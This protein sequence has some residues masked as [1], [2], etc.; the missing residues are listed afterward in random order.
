MCLALG[1]TR[2]CSIPLSPHNPSPVPG[3]ANEVQLG[4]FAFCAT[5]GGSCCNNATEEELRHKASDKFV[6]VLHHHTSSLRGILE[7]TGNI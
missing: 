6:T 7:D 4:V 2:T 1:R 5:C 3:T